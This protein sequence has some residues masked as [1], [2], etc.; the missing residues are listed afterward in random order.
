MPAQL[1]IG[2]LRSD[3][4]LEEVETVPIRREG[5]LLPATIHRKQVA[6]RRQAVYPHTDVLFPCLAFPCHLSAVIE[7][8]VDSSTCDSTMVSLLY[9]ERIIVGHVQKVSPNSPADHYAASCRYSQ[10]Q[11]AESPLS[12]V[13]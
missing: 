2:Q 5:V 10:P 12:A 8:L 4:A 13:C 11:S 6:I 3:E 7:Q 9:S 1:S